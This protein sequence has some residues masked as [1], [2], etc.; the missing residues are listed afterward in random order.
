MI[1]RLWNGLKE[2][3]IQDKI[4]II[5]VG[6]HGMVLTDSDGNILLLAVNSLEND[7]YDREHPFDV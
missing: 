1:G 7:T 6:D 5:V 2:R 4:N 3:S